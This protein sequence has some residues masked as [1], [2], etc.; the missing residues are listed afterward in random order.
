MPVVLLPPPT[1][2]YPAQIA[3][4]RVFVLIQATASISGDT[5]P[6]VTETEI[7]AGGQTTVIDLVNDTWVA[8][9]ATFNAER[10]AIING[11]DSDGV[12]LL[13]WDL[14]VK[15]L[16]GV[17]GVVRTSDTVVTITW[18]AF[19]T[20]SITAPETITVTVPASALVG[21]VALA[22]TPA[23]FEV[24]EGGAAAFVPRLALMGVG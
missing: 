20:Y 9:G 17:A 16:Q 24:T 3:R 10:Q 12:E 22:T 19:A 23:S 2:P 18:D 1:R 4:P 8:A 13:G 21:G 7:V 14:V 6:S 15:A 5:V 11:C